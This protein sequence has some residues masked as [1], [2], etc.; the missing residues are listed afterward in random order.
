[1]IQNIPKDK[2]V[3]YFPL[4]EEIKHLKNIL[5][6]ISARGIV[7]GYVDDLKN[8]NII[9]IGG[10]LAGD[11]NSPL[12]KDILNKIPEKMF[13]RVSGPEW[14]P[15]LKNHWELFGYI[16]RT[17]FSTR[18]L[19]LNHI[20]NLIQPLPEG[21][22]LETVDLE[23]VKLLEEEWPRGDEW[24][25]HCGGPAGFV[26]DTVNYCIKKGKKVVSMVVGDLAAVPITNSIEL[27]IYT[28]PEYRGR[29]FASLACAKF[30]EHCL[31][32]G[33]EPHWDAANARSVKL[34]LKLGYTDPVPY[35]C[36]YW[37]SE[38]WTK[39]ELQNIFDQPYERISKEIEEFKSSVETLLSSNQANKAR[40]ITTK[41]CSKLVMSLELI[42]SD[43]DRL[44]ETGIVYKPDVPYFEEYA[45]K[46]H[47]QVEDLRNFV[48]ARMI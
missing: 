24:I 7:D 40:N 13:I 42:S 29:G 47:K 15:L 43:I 8:P 31:E 10:Y 36:Y 35:K 4:F 38:P 48:T 6:F 16:T 12:L 26:K 19:S 34:A 25:E 45:V 32:Q 20:R 23:T 18:N 37:R 2:L 3:D 30:I 41:T 28:L 9:F 44:I 1:M 46:I 22:T 17:S 5:A 21:F 33:I 14:E 27:D 39:T 11:K